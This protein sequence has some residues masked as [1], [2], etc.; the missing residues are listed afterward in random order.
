MNKQIYIQ[1][2]LIHSFSNDEKNI[3]QIKTNKFYDTFFKRYKIMI[4]G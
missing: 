2:P 4:Y 1:N 3:I